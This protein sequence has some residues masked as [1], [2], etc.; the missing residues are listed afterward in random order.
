M[1][2]RN[3]YGFFTLSE[4][5]SQEALVEYYREK[6]YQTAAGGYEKAYSAEEI[7]Y[8]NNKIEEKFFVIETHREGGS[9]PPRL[10]DIGCGEGWVLNFFKNKG[11]DVLGI[12][13]S[14]HGCSK[15]NPDCLGQLKSGD[16]YEILG[17]LV[18]SD[19]RF[20][21]VWLDNVLEHVL[22]PESLVQD[23]R[24]VMAETGLLTVEVPNDFSRL[25]MHLLDKSHI[26]REF[27][28]AVPDH[29][30]YFNRSGLESLMASNGWQTVSMIADYPIDWNLLN[31]NTNYVMDKSKGKSCH[32]ERVAFENLLHHEPIDKVVAFYKAMADLGLGRQLVGFFELK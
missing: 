4:K 31:H 19:E 2:V 5:P 14:E 9:K 22:D 18:Q 24:K 32:L 23:I 13:Y 15:F 17:Q 20:D 21:V 3:K 25:Q 6:Y 12:D 8:F 29:I 26:D 1:V 30:S 7:L 28:V 11:W 27:W 16:I 10:L